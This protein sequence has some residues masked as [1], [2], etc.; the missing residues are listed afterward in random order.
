MI[1]VSTYNSSNIYAFNNL[2]IHEA[3]TVR[4]KEQEETLLNFFEV[5]ITLIDKKAYQDYYKDRKT[6]VS[7]YPFLS[8]HL[9]K[10]T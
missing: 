10:K 4:T 8:Y 1:K 6:D 9:N 7:E 2:K 3:N 5:N